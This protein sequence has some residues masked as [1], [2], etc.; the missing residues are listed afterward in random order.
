VRIRRILPPAAAPLRAADI[1][2]G[3]RGLWTG[4]KRLRRFRAEAGRY[5]G[6]REVFPV[7]SGK[8]ALVL[9]LRALRRLAPGRHKV[10]IPAYTCFSVP[11]A[12]RKAGLTVAVCDL[13]QGTLDFDYS[14]LQEMVDAETLCVVATHLFGFTADVDRARAVCRN[15]NAYLVEDAAQAMGG[16]REGKMLGTFGDAGFFSLGRGKNLTC[17][18]GGIVVTSSEAIGSALAAEYGDIEAPSFAGQV[19]TLLKVILTDMLQHPAA[20]WFPSRLKFLRLGETVFHPDFPVKRMGGVEAGILSE[21][22]SRLEELNRTRSENVRHYLGLTGQVDSGTP[23]IPCPRFPLLAVD[24]EARNRI[25][26]SSLREG[27]GIG[28]MYPHPVHEI[29]EIR[30]CHV[31]GDSFPVAEKVARM[32]ITLPTHRFVSS[33]DRGRIG[34]LLSG[35]RVGPACGSPGMRV[36]LRA[37]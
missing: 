32:L 23:P 33:A 7:S 20:Y 17:G 28:R 18:D 6:A 16:K 10:V 35:F 26:E 13:A 3:I 15:G 4:E 5:F 1:L 11:S 36:G 19:M 31:G 22:V 30:T 14:R 9:I 24:E 37:S 25:Y 21:F 29:A 12:I 34:R 27:L 8:S 2:G